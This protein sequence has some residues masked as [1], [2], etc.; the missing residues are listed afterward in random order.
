MAKSPTEPEQLPKM[1]QLTEVETEVPVILTK[2]RGVFHILFVFV[3]LVLTFIYSLYIP[4]IDPL[5]VTLSHNP[6]LTSILFSSERMA[7]SLISSHPDTSSFCGSRSSSPTETKRGSLDRRPG[8][9]SAT[10]V[11]ED[12]STAHVCSLA[13]ASVS[14]GPKGPG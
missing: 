11:W 6:P 12:L 9:T 5:L 8:C 1:T 2:S 10:C 13:G 7:P 14:E 3:W 4:F